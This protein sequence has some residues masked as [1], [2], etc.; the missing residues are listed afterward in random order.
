MFLYPGWSWGIV[1]ETYCDPRFILFFCPKTTH[2]VGF[3]GHTGSLNTLGSAYTLLGCIATCFVPVACLYAFSALPK[4]L[5]TYSVSNQQGPTV[6]I[7]RMRGAGVLSMAVAV[8]LRPHLGP[9]A[10]KK[11]QHSSCLV[12]NPLFGQRCQCPIAYRFATF[13]VVPPLIAI[14]GGLVRGSTPACG[15][16]GM[17]VVANIVP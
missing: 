3:L 4:F 10:G 7:S 11:R 13:G 8:Q 15:I 12:P 6:T 16:N 1:R 14:V 5:G 17:G 9:G 2:F